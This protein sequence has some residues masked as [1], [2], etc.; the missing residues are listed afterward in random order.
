MLASSQSL[1]AHR[2]S[3]IIAATPDLCSTPFPRD[4][5]LF[6]AASKVWVEQVTGSGEKPHPSVT[7]GIS[8]E[9]LKQLNSDN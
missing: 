2:L 8:V 7:V 3:P 9:Q 1:D 5:N 4:S 6:E